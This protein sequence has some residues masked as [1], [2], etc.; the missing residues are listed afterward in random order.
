M[1]VTARDAA[2]R[3]EPAA[4]TG[5]PEA[6]APERAWA[7]REFRGII[8]AQVTS[9]CGDQIAAIALSYLV[10]SRS[11]SPFLAAAT[12]AVQYLPLTLGSIFLAP[13]VDRLSRR[14]VMLVADLARGAIAAALVV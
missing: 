12:Y 3:A 7:N 11:N 1:R 13:L 6:A 9:E 5:V 10:Y 4:I 8:A 14:R 2:L